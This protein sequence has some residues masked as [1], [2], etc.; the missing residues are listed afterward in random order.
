MR[1]KNVSRFDHRF[2]GW[3]V[4]VRRGGRRYY[5]YF[6]DSRHG[7]RRGSFNAAV[8]HR[9]GLLTKLP[10]A[11]AVR[12]L[13]NG[14]ARGVYVERDRNGRAVRYGASWTTVRG[15]RR[16]R[17]F[18]VGRFGGGRA[19]E[20]ARRARARGLREVRAAFGRLTRLPK[21]RRHK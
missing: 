2:H 3:V 18:A 4:S 12:R 20:L 1:A 5:K 9:D 15:E 13:G 14:A 16:R 17:T 11:L 7:G 8:R 10:P 21:A 6:S 19:H